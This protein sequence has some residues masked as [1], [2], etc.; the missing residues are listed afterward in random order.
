MRQKAEEEWLVFRDR[1]SKYFHKFLKVRRNR[2]IINSIEDM[3]GETV[4]GK[5]GITDIF[6]NHFSSNLDT[7]NVSSLT[8]ERLQ[9]LNL[10]ILKDNKN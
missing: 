3:N 9:Q 1:C 5:D 2:S 8:M 4:K 10:K 7:G 6:N